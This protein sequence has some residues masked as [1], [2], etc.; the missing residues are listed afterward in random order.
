MT[1][2]FN[3]LD[4]IE[5]LT[6][7]KGGKYICPVCD[8]NDLSVSKKGAYK[9]W[10]T[11]CDTGKIRDAVAPWSSEQKE[12]TPRNQHRAAMRP[13][14]KKELD[15]QA[16]QEEVE[17]D[18]QAS[19]FASQVAHGAMSDSEALLAMSTWCKAH[20]HNTF[21]AQ[22]LLQ[23]KIKK[24]R[25]ALP[26]GGD[27]DEKPKMLRDYELI[28]KR[29]GDKFRWNELFKWV[30]FEKEEFDVSLAKPFF[31]IK[32]RVNVK[33]GREDISDIVV[34]LAKDEPF[35]PVVA[36][37]DAV[38]ARFGDKTSILD[39]AADRYLGCK[40]PIHNSCLMRWL[41]SA[42]ARAYEPG[43]KVDNVLILQ[44]GQ[45]VGKSTFFAILASRDW[46]DDSFGNSSDKDERLKLHRTWIVEWAEIEN[47]FKRRD[48]SAIKNFITTQTD[49]LRP[50]YGRTIRPLKRPSVFCGST[51]QREF[52][53]D[54]TGNRRFWVVPVSKSVPFSQLTAD[55]DEIWAAAVALY[56][57]GVSW[58]LDDEEKAEMAIE[59][60][61]YEVTDIWYDEILDFCNG[62]EFVAITDILEVR[63][64]L[65]KSQQDRKTQIR[66]KGILS[67]AGWEPMPNPIWLG[68]SK[69]RVWKNPIFIVI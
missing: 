62:R 65:P 29:F 68:E 69:K 19:E 34:M 52:L 32:Q 7:S 61:A 39:A 24:Y 51:N 23:E 55:R 41:I 10:S 66:V 30:E 4:H 47:A 20:K 17:I 42:V 3:M 63:F 25:S 46:F 35:N 45:G 37:L 49:A 48:V 8:G 5:K 2:T 67:K 50:P 1:A 64:N 57:A 33:S 43:C 27:D 38:S 31:S 60:A 6:P 14:S 40:K 36:Y 15:S 13:P 12:R 58:E 26:G 21:S 18:S 54:E 16:L 22:K 11:G 56:R 53:A 28:Q 44:G 9:C 59:R